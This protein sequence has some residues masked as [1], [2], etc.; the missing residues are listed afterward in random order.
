MS[1]LKSCLLKSPELPSKPQIPMHEALETIRNIHINALFE[2]ENEGGTPQIRCSDCPSHI[3]TNIYEFSGHLN[4]E[5]HKSSMEK[6]VR[7]M[8]DLYKQVR[9]RYGFTGLFIPVTG[10]NPCT[11]RSMM[12]CELCPEWGHKI[13]QRDE[14]R[15]LLEV[16]KSHLQSSGHPVEYKEE[17]VQE[18][19][20]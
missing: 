9:H 10:S 5:E 16:G 20:V 15:S 4:S 2:V 3:F 14:V 18:Y 11:P 6:R 12:K 7:L 17:E 13:V 1:P 8:L 19:M